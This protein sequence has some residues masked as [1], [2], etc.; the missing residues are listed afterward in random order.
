MLSQGYAI[1]SI[2]CK[3]IKPLINPS[4]IRQIMYRP[5]SEKNNDDVIWRY[6]PFVRG[7]HW[8][9][10]NSPHTGQ[11]HA[12][13]IFSLI[14]FWTHGWANNQDAGDLKC[15]HANYDVAVML[16]MP[17][18]SITYEPYLNRFWIF[19]QLGLICVVTIHAMWVPWRLKP[20]PT[21]LFLQKLTEN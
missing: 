1:K 17:Y 10:V 2:D 19:V 12:A 6:W 13:L 7:I 21:R 5:L 18:V 15:H 9:P 20:P 11:W 14:C 3:N 4:A 8:W 16:S